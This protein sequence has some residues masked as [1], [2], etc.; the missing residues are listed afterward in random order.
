[1]RKEKSS[2]LQSQPLRLGQRCQLQCFP[3]GRST[4]SKALPGNIAFSVFM[5]T[6][7]LCT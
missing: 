6:H 2:E 4:V 3:L 5:G 7:L 1:M